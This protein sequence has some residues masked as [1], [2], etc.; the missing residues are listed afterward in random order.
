MRLSDEAYL[1]LNILSV[2]QCFLGE[3]IRLYQAHDVKLHRTYNSLQTCVQIHIKRLM[4]L[5]LIQRKGK[6]MSYLYSLTN[7]GMQTLIKSL[8]KK[9]ITL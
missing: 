1:I 6:E 8:L 7:K 2:R 3:L 9:I 4:K 5:G